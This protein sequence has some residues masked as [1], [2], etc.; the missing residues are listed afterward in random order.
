MTGKRVN[1]AIFAVLIFYP[2]FVWFFLRNS[3]T[4]P[5]DSETLSRFIIPFR[6]SG[7]ANVP[8]AIMESTQWDIFRPIYSLS[9][10][11]DYV[12]WGTNSVGYHATDVVLS[13]ISYGIAFFLLK[14]RFGLPTATLAILLWALHPA[15][16][17][18]LC[19][20]FARNDRLVTLFT[21]SALSSYDLSIDRVHQRKLFFSF[22]L[23]L[24]IMAVTSKETGI[25][26][27]LLLPFWSI[28]VR[29]RTLRETV[30]SD[31]FLWMGV[32]FTGVLF[33]LLRSLAGFNASIDAGGFTT[34]LSYL[35]NLA[36]LIE[37]G[38]PIPSAIHQAPLTTCLVTGAIISF[39]V[40]CR[41]CPEAVRFGALA[42]SVFAVPFPFFW[43]QKSFLWGCTLWG[44]LAVASVLIQLYN[45]SKTSSRRMLSVSFAIL[46]VL[47]FTGSALWSG[48]TS[49]AITAHM[50]EYEAVAEYAISTNSGPYYRLEILAEHFP[51]LEDKLNAMPEQ[52]NSKISN[53]LSELI[54]IKAGTRYV[55]VR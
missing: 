25:F 43:V 37:A 40:L 8:W 29:K 19:K 39:A 55:V 47:V 23:I 18:S 10:L 13:W 20:I 4:T 49:K 24:I 45:R 54:Q 11:A 44:S 35:R 1:I 51:G 42:I 5:F 7:S 15:Q 17:C 9:V 50:I 34:G 38:L 22:T 21:I 31:L 32:F 48:L 33:I 12:L 36:W 52:E 3:I 28:L 2:L 6:F 41:K 27:T 53:Y 30:H 26:Y 14:R 46:V 16:P